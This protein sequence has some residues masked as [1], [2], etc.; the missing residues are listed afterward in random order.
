[1]VWDRRGL[2]MARVQLPPAAYCSN[3]STLLQKLGAADVAKSLPGDFFGSV[4]PQS[5][6]LVPQ[7]NDTHGA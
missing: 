7:Y 3:A 1:M 4:C 2:R 6:Y 5:V